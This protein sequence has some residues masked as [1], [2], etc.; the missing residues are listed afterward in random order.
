M[1]NNNYGTVQNNTEIICQVN[2][3]SKILNEYIEFGVEPYKNTVHQQSDQFV[4]STGQSLQHNQL[5]QS[6]VNF[7]PPR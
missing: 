4:Q 2:N 6:P 7:F 3:Y 1:T 5:L